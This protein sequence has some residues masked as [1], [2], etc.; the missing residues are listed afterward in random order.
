M[1]QARQFICEE[2]WLNEQL[3]DCRF[4][5]AFSG[6]DA[7]QGR[8]CTTRSLSARPGAFLQVAQGISHG[9]RMNLLLVCSLNPAAYNPAP[10][11]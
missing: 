9:L 5:I 2:R 10:R 3:G 6:A 4:R 8:L 11:V 7:S 1:L